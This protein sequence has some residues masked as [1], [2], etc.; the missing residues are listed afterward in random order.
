[1]KF[2]YKYFYKK[3]NNLDKTIIFTSE[4]KNASD[5]LIEYLKNINLIN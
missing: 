5:Q 1:M 3:F 2:I 4:S